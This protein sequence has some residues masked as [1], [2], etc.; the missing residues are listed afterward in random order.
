[1]AQPLSLPLTSGVVSLGLPVRYRELSRF[2]ARRSCVDPAASASRLSRMQGRRNPSAAPP[3]TQS[4]LPPLARPAPC[5]LAG[6]SH[7]CR[8][9]RG[10]GTGSQVALW[11]GLYS[12]AEGYGT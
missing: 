12:V 7:F 10:A 5:V 2:W 4:W 11:G 1:M 8:K 9:C 6:S 3:P